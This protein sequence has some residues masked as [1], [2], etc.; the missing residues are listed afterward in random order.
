MLKGVVCQEGGGGGSENLV[1]HPDSASPPGTAGA[2][3]LQRNGSRLVAC[4]A[5][6]DALVFG[7]L[8]GSPEFRVRI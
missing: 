2:K 7:R 5:W 8:R 3:L 1:S 6:A 4:D